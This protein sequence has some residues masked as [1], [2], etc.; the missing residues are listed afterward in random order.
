MNR[1]YI[2]SHQLLQQVQILE[3]AQGAAAAAAGT[4]LS[5]LGANVVKLVLSET[6][7]SELDIRLNHRGKSLLQT[8]NRKVVDEALSRADILITDFTQTMLKEIG[9]DRQSSTQWPQLIHAHISALG[10]DYDGP[11]ISDDAA[12]Y[13]RSGTTGLMSS[14]KPLRFGRGQASRSGAFALT[15]AVIAELLRREVTGFAGAV[16]TTLL[17]SGIYSISNDVTVVQGSRKQPPRYD[18]SEPLNALGNSYCCADGKW[19]LLGVA[20]AADAWNKFQTIVDDPT[21][22]HKPQFAN[23]KLRRINTPSIV[24]LL[25]IEF[26]L[27][28]REEWSKRL[29]RI[30]INWNPIAMPEDVISDPQVIAC[31]T[32]SP[33]NFL[34]TPISVQN[35]PKIDFQLSLPKFDISSWDQKEPPIHHKNPDLP[36]SG[37]RVLDT[38]HYV[39]APALGALLVD[40]GAEVIKVEPPG[41]DPR[42]GAL[43]HL[44]KGDPPGLNRS[45]HM[46]NRGKRSVEVDLSDPGSLKRL[47]TFI[48]SCDIY[49]TNMLPYRQKKY[50]LDGRS[51]TSTNPNLI[52]VSLTAHGSKGPAANAGGFDLTAFFARSGILGNLTAQAGVP[53]RSR[54]GQGDHIATLV[55]LTGLLAA[56]HKQRKNQTG[57]II[58]TSLLAIGTYSIGDELLRQKMKLTPASIRPADNYY[59][60]S[61]GQWLR[62]GSRTSDS[63]FNEDVKTISKESLPY[64]LEF[65]R[66]KG[67][68]AMGIPD[69]TEVLA[70]R[71]VQQNDILDSID[72]PPIGAIGTVRAPYRF[73]DWKVRPFTRGP[74]LGEHNELLE[75]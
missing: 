7:F 50:G 65:Y 62:L 31:E 54:S 74:N 41:G 2:I 22:M 37:M 23:E 4:I 36:L 67:I 44:V 68:P 29:S 45:Y 35:N 71:L 9:L 14:G 5:D 75:N 69:M 18:R 11:Q 48:E 38:S 63:P 64:W 34:H 10:Y 66:K 16:E 26:A 43:P 51:L 46:D 73:L 30:G 15:A 8:H 19:L 47:H 20:S 49:L 24:K 53:P 6:D 13:V 70:D 40:L 52:Y 61:D 55:L 60:C 12:F 32:L 56:V 25:E 3:L 1:E 58:E 28:P 59:Q 42:R 33:L 57:S 27:H 17:A 39:A 21:W 72:V